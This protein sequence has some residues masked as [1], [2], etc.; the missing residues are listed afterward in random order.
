[1]TAETA[2]A[3]FSRTRLLAYGFPGLPL[4]A[5]GVPLFIF[6]PAFYA[7]ERGL[8]L[9]AVGLVLLVAR[10]WDAVSDPVIGLLSDRI[11]TRLGRRK[12]WLLAGTPLTCLSIYMLFVPPEGAGVLHLFA[13]SAAL[14]LGWTMVQL[15]YTAW[16]AE[17]SGDYHE[18]SRV[19]AFRETLVVLGTL[20]ASGMP[21]TISAAGGAGGKDLGQVLSVL[22][23][24]LVVALPVSVLLA[25]GLV[26][27]RRPPEQA[28]A[29]TMK[30]WRSG[31]ALLIRNRPF[32][33]LILAYLL[34]GLANGLAA[35][36]FVLFV[37]KGLGLPDEVDI[38]LLTYFLLGISGVPLWLFVSHRLGKHRAW[39]IAMLLNSAIFATVPLLGPGDYAAFLAICIGTGLC[40]GADLVL[41]PSM[42]ADVVDVDTAEGGSSRAG[43]YFALWGMATKLALALAVG[44]AFP[45]LDFAGFDASGDNAPRAL[46]ALSLLYGAAP[47][48]LKLAAISIMRGFPITAEKQAELRRK[49]EQKT[50]KSSPGS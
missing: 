46:L 34:N 37:E 15:P 43:L 14:Y 8:S 50:A 1:M 33:R 38:L 23:A 5:L 10:L 21:A 27:E 17:L 26:P 49:I 3:A 36:L 47:V 31:A 22:A 35:T 30:Q 28:T 39:I 24:F 9:A 19:T 32:L 20:V 11:T 42:Q 13:W 48:V 4:A 44:I 29:S 16:G 45:L 40:L 41:P 6:L 2:G 18:R 12:P 7:Q 25:T